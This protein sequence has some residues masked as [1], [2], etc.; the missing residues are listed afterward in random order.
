M[1]HPITRTTC[2]RATTSILTNI[3]YWPIFK[4]ASDIL[5]PIRNGTAQ[6]IL[7]SLCR[8]AGELDSL[9]A[10]SQHDL[11]GRMFQRLITDRKFLATFYTLPSSATLLADLAVARLDVH[12]SNREAVAALKI[13][14]FACGTGALLN[15]AY[16]AV[17]SRYRRT[18]GDDRDIHPE[19]MEHALVG[20]DIMPAATHLTASVLSS[21][22][23]SVTFGDTSIL[24]LPIWRAAGGVRPTDRDRCLGPDPRGTNPSFVRHR[25]ESS[26]GA[27]PRAMAPSQTCPMTRS[28]L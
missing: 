8:V 20:T 6:E 4:I 10:T 16:E 13:A 19:M 1:K 5:R 15:A 7:D 23:P 18:G 21:T 12:W 25:A 9:G 22:H 24:T 2:V 11:C 26:A 28:I 14:D 17:L 27:V 3:N